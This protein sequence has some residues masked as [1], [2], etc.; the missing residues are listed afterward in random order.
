MFD[1]QMNISENQPEK[2]SER[3]K[4]PNEPTNLYCNVNLRAKWNPLPWQFSSRMGEEERQ[5]H[6]EKD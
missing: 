1:A 6:V 2:S 3:E 4:E 5:I